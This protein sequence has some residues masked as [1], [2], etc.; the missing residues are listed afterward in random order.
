MLRVPNRA[1]GWVVGGALAI[2]AVGMGVAPIR[3]L[4]RFT[5]PSALDLAAAGFTGA[6]ALIAF[7]FVKRIGHGAGTT[8]ASAKGV[9]AP[10][11]NTRHWRRR[12]SRS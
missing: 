8:L 9:R 7:E 6:L 12:A 4:L 5:R 3:E 2:L 11:V 10:G 1:L